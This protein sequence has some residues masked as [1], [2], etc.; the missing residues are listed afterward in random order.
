MKKTFGI[1][2]VFIAFLCSCST[3]KTAQPLK[4]PILSSIAGPVTKPD[5]SY[6][7]EKK[8]LSPLFGKLLD[9]VSRSDSSFNPSLD[10]I[11]Y[12]SY[13]LSKPAVVTVNVYDPDQ[14]LVAVLSDDPMKKGTHRIT[15]DGHDMD[16]LV[17]ADEAYF[18]TIIAK[19]KNGQT[20]IYDP[21]TFSGGQSHDITKVN[22]DPQQYSINYNM[23]EMGRIMIRMGI[24]GGPLMNQLVDWKPRVKGVVTEYWNGMDTDNLI[25]IKNHPNF[26]MIVTYHSLPENSIIAFGNQ[27]G[28]YL[29]YKKKLNSE[30]P[31]KPERE[32]SM[33]G[34]SPHYSLERSV[35]YSPGIDVQFTNTHG[36]DKNGLTILNKKTMVKITLKEE[37]KNIFQNH[38]FEICLFL[39]HKFYAEDETGYT[40]FNWVWDLSGVEAG[41]H[42]LTVN[43]SSFQDQI[44]LMSK[45]VLVVK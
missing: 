37:D 33:S 5:K 10:Q 7:P 6:L 25:N 40:P 2:L 31:L 24:Q 36:R 44:G 3:Q 41:E 28:N 35:D 9:K 21:T 26:K 12:L 4:E 32:T 19:D 29:D 15:W 38:Q 1:V 16:G 22:I 34:L 13:T 27:S 39:D 42:L 18:F 20:E 17:V 11:V 14:R 23:P 8:R 45:K 43:I 30:R